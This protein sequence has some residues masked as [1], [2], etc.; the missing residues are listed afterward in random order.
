MKEVSWKV[1]GLVLH[2]GLQQKTTKPV[3]SSCIWKII[4]ENSDRILVAKNWTGQ[5]N[6]ET[7]ASQNQIEQVTFVYYHA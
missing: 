7:M 6:S 3:I 2:N 1:N 5:V 4:E